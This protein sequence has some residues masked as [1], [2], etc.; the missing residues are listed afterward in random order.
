[1]AILNLFVQPAILE[2]VDN[3]TEAQKYVFRK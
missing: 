3:A 2:I 1:M